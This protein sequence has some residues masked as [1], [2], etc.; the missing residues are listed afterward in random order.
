MNSHFT[1]NKSCRKFNI[2]QCIVVCL[3]L[4]F[5]PNS[6]SAADLADSFNFEDVS[7]WR[8]LEI[9]Y[10]SPKEGRA[11][12]RWDD[13]VNVDR[14]RLEAFP[15]D[16]SQYDALA[17]WVYSQKATNA[18]IAI[19]L[20]SENENSDGSD[21][22]MCNV[23]IDWTGWKE[24]AIPFNEMKTIREP[25]GLNDIDYLRIASSGYGCGDANPETRLKLDAMRL[26]NYDKDGNLVHPLVPVDWRKFDGVAI[27]KTL[28]ETGHVLLYVRSNSFPLCQEFEKTYLLAEEMQR[29]LQGRTVYFVEVTENPLVA[30]QL[31][32]LKVPAFVLVSNNQDNQ[33]EYV[34]DLINPA[35][36]ITFLG[37]LPHIPLTPSY[38][39]PTS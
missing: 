34:N 17:I 25:R 36:I 24:I 39:K 38:L 12:G 28:N 29:V 3:A 13:T 35:P 5:A 21:Y 26:M 27:N 22:Y 37:R 30:Q 16:V 32:V 23:T 6:S 31:K 9:D 19:V 15:R 2:P 18:M 1:K 14:L 10:R 33:I 20:V 8:G 11:S 4:I 7:D